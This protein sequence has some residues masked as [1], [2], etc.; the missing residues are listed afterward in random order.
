MAR[1][2]ALFKQADVKRAVAGA[3]AA[4][5]AV[6]R[7][8]IEA[9]KITIHSENAAQPAAPATDLDKWMASHADKA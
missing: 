5:L 3:L 2:P 9:D 7:V 1:A 6:G 8:E 4:G